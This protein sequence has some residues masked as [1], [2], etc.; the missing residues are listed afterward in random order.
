MINTPLEFLLEKS[1]ISLDIAYVDP[2]DK[3]PSWPDHDVL[4][5]AADETDENKPVLR[6]IAELIVDWRRPV[7]NAPD[8]IANL[9]RSEAW[10]LL[11]TA[12]GLVIPPTLR[13]DRAFLQRVSRRELQAH[14]LFDGLAFPLLVRPRWS[15]AGNGLAKIDEAVALGSYL[16]SHP[17]ADFFVSPFIDYRSTD[18][19]FRKYRIALIDGLPYAIHL[20]ISSYW[21]IHYVTSGMKFDSVRRNE[22]AA[23]MAT[24]DFDFSAR[25]AV[26][27]DAI[28]K[29][30]GLD[31]VIVDCGETRDGQLLVFEIGTGMIV[32]AMDPPKIFPYKKPQMERVFTAFQKML[33]AAAARNA[34]PIKSGIPPNAT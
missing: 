30:S 20:A 13:A 24:F 8:K 28:A 7:L 22:E 17:D 9:S 5:I 19:L 33:Y 11:G 10:Q 6:R 25:H 23:F 12:P 34:E 3:A 18:G 31:Y 32:H 15:H 2:A 14:S 27:L 1:K 29:R 4:F 16:D 26:A 21:M